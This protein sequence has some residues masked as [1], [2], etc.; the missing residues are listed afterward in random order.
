VEYFRTFTV[1]PQ[2]RTLVWPNDV[3]LAPEFLHDA[4]RTNPAPAP[5]VRGS[6]A[7]GIVLMTEIDESRHT[8]DPMPVVSRFLGIVISMYHKE[9]G[10]PHFHA[11]YG[12]HSISFEIESGVV[13]G[14]LPPRALRHVR[15]WAALHRAALLKNWES[16]RQKKRI[17]PI[18]PLE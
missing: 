13:H 17:D 11:A 5:R 12:G 8:V 7:S 10:V 1:H 3:D 15:E 16:A 6:A 18:P 14:S 2:F 9:H 4:A